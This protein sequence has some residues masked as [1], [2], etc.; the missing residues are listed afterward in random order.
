MVFHGFSCY[1][2]STQQNILLNNPRNKVSFCLESQEDQIYFIFI[3]EISHNSFTSPWER[4]RNQ[5]E[6]WRAWI[7]KYKISRNSF[8]C[9]VVSLLCCLVCS[10][11]KSRVLRGNGP[12]ILLTS[13][14]NLRGTKSPWCG[15]YMESCGYPHLAEP[16]LCANEW[17]NYAWLNLTQNKDQT[18]YFC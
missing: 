2:F 10:H 8:N 15:Q 12:N 13:V 16:G 1:F 17:Q 7:P 6:M 9:S 11:L 5:F 4:T 18:H 3:S 14:M